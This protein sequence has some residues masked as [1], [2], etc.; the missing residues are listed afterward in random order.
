MLHTAVW[1]ISVTQTKT[2]YNF[3]K[4]RTQHAYPQVLNNLR[5]TTRHATNTGV[6]SPKRIK[7]TPPLQVGVLHGGRQVST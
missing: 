1:A 7:L 2:G 4:Q 6:S 5:R 3:N